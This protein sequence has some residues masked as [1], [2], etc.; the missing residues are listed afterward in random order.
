MWTSIEN[1]AS[2]LDFIP[3]LDTPFQIVRL[4]S[5]GVG[6]CNNHTKI[7]SL[8]HIHCCFLVFLS[9]GEKQDEIET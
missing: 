8:F 2:L 5:E 7:I 6:N 4:S 9:V 3:L 1:R